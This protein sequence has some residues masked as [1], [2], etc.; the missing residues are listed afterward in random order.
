MARIIN[1][2]GHLPDREWES[3]KTSLQARLDNTITI[4]QRCVDAST[5]IYSQIRENE[6]ANLPDDSNL[7]AQYTMSQYRI[8]YRR[9]DVELLSRIMECAELETQRREN[10]RLYQIATAVI[11]LCK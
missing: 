9:S 6:A 8:N 2:W 1:M 11:G 3:F 5:Q 7:Y 10:A 4:L